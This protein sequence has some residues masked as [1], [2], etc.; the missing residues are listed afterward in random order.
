MEPDPRRTVVSR[1]DSEIREL[2]AW[3]MCN[4]ALFKQSDHH[5]AVQKQAEVVSLLKT[6]GQYD[7]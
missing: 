4:W 3:S 6:K 1:S 2:K 7:L 5:W